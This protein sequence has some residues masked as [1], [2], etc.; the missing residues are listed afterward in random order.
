MKPYLTGR[1]AP[2]APMTPG[3]AE[4]RAPASPEVRNTKTW[5]LGKGTFE[6]TNGDGSGGGSG[7]A[8]DPVEAICLG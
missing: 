4:R 3:A 6:E 1:A 8:D 2:A 7:E 5:S